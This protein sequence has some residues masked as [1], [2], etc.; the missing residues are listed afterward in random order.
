VRWVDIIFSS[1]EMDSQ[2]SLV[3]GPGDRAAF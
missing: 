2:G 1:S 3:V